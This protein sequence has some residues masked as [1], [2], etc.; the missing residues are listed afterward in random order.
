VV[1][2]ERRLS[3]IFGRGR[4]W[5]AGVD[6]A[7]DSIGLVAASVDASHGIVEHAIFG[8]DLR[9]RLPAPSSSNRTRKESSSY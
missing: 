3:P 6:H 5:L 7:R 8:E 4:L 2:F 9:N 1:C